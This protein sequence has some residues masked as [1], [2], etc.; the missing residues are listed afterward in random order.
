MA[1]QD[2]EMNSFTPVQDAAYVYAEDANG[3][4]VKIKKN[5]LVGL[6]KNIYLSRTHII[7]DTPLSTANECGCYFVR[8]SSDSPYPYAMLMVDKAESQGFIIIRQEIF[9]YTTWDSK[10]RIIRNGVADPWR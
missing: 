1:G 5:D 7:G 10:K 9:D 3:N 6:F 8:Q 2:I 4:Q